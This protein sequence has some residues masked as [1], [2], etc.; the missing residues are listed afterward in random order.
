M[1]KLTLRIKNMTC[2]SCISLL[3]IQLESIGVEVE[4]IKLGEATIKKP[5]NLSLE[6]VEEVL[7]SN[8][9]VSIADDE[10]LI[11]EE[12]KLAVL[13]LVKRQSRLN[14]EVKNSDFIAREV[15]RSYRTLSE[16]FSRH[17]GVTI[18]R[19]IIQQKIKRTK[20]LLWEGELSLSQIAA[21]LGYSSVQHLSGQFKR[22]EG[23]SV[24]DYKNGIDS[25]GV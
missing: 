11:V 23:I 4:D 7:N 9:F 15:G 8:G 21:E 6:A 19:Y 25:E 10:K 14:D 18:E 12:V 24:S 17:E 22:V 5:E 13:K 1:E 3:K 2:P 16:L 20:E